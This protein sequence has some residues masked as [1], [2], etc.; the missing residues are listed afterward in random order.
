MNVSRWLVRI[1]IK[2]ND[3]KARATSSEL[4]CV[5]TETIVYTR[6]VAYGAKSA[7]RFAI[8]PQLLKSSYILLGGVD[9]QSVTVHISSFR[10]TS[11][12]FNSTSRRWE[13]IVSRVPVSPSILIDFMLASI[14]R[15]VVIRRWTRTTHCFCAGTMCLEIGIVPSTQTIYF[16]KPVSVQFV[17]TRFN[18]VHELRE[19]TVGTTQVRPT[20]RSKR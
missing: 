6:N 7:G 12:V 1:D 5:L 2:D 11:D 20:C 17:T 9:L 4:S 3:V 19:T 10:K 15:V 13:T 18:I 8:L 16:V 14:V